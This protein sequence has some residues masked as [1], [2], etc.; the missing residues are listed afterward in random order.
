MIPRIIC[1]QCELRQAPVQQ[2]RRCKTAFE[3]PAA[4]GASV[5][6]TELQPMH[7][8]ERGLILAA[9]ARCG[10]DAMRAANALGIGKSTLYRKLREYRGATSLSPLP[11]PSPRAEIAPHSRPTEPPPAESHSCDQAQ[12]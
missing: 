3:Y 6:G 7:Q 11:H 12:F 8:A 2:C 1:P 4:I 5:A 9:M 10:D